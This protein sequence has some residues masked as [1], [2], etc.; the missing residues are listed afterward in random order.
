MT[1]TT[2]VAASA[3]VVEYIALAPVVYAALAA[4]VEYMVLRFTVLALKPW[5]ERGC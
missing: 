3:L 5:I 4:V 1:G 2:V